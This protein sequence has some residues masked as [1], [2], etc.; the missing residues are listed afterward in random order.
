MLARATRQLRCK[1]FQQSRLFTSQRTLS[2]IS[3]WDIHIIPGTVSLLASG[4]PSPDEYRVK[5][6]SADEDSQIVLFGRSPVSELV[7]L[8]LPNEELESTELG[9]YL[10]VQ[11]PDGTL[12]R[13]P[14]HTCPTEAQMH[15]EERAGFQATATTGGTGWDEPPHVMAHL[16]GCR[17]A[18]VAGQSVAVM[19]EGRPLQPTG[20]AAGQ[21]LTSAYTY[22]AGGVVA[23]AALV[24]AV[25]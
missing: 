2:Y 12:A 18:L 13:Y 22:V 16:V 7:Q 6:A 14:A 3:D 20:A 24:Y 10:L 25:L 4:G 15:V 19:G 21:I 11:H 9:V 23:V 5:L 8:L 17:M 1:K